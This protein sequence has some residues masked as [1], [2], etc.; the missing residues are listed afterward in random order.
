MHTLVTT[1]VSICLI[2]SFFFE[3]ISYSF[4]FIAHIKDI[5][6]EEWYKM[7]DENVEKLKGKGLNLCTEDEFKLNGSKVT[8]VPK[9]QK[10]M[11]QTNNAYMLVYMH[12]SMVTKLKTEQY[13]WELSPRL[14]HLV[15]ARND[16]FENAILNIK[17]NREYVEDKDKVCV[18]QM[19]NL[20]TEMNSTPVKEG[21]REAISLQWLNY[22]F[23]I[24][25]NQ[26]VK[27][28]CN[29]AI[30]CKHA[31]LDP[32]KVHEVKYIGTDLVCIINEYFKG[33]SEDNFI[34]FQADK[35]YGIYKGGPRLKLSS[36]LCW[37]C[38]RNKCALLYTKTFTN[39]QNKTI[40]TVL[41]NWNQPNSSE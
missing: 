41:Q 37:K 34:F 21:E 17:S 15:E 2:Y 30:L 38:V 23:K 10:G 35:L 6:A 9:I 29:N 8:K 3:L 25:P 19:L 36:S 40:T 27:E 31:L 5:A 16:N 18:E 22:W 4:Y 11:L 26:S 20:I 13:N 14:A 12:T 7:N 1:S 33:Y 39:E 28:I 24:T 32:D